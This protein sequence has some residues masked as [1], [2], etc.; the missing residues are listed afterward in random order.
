MKHLTRKVVSLFTALTVAAGLCTLP[1]AAAETPKTEQSSVKAVWPG[2]KLKALTG[3]FDDGT[4]N[5]D[6]EKWLVDTFKANG[7]KATF[8]LPSGNLPDGSMDKY[9]ALYTGFEVAS[10]TK[11]HSFYGNVSPARYIDETRYDIEKLSKIAPDNMV[12]GMAYPNGGSPEEEQKAL[13]KEAGIQYGRSTCSTRTFNLPDDL[14]NW[15]PTCFQYNINDLEADAQK[16]IN[17]APDS[18][19]LMY[20][21]GHSYQLN[22]SNKPRTKAVYEA[23]GNRGDI[24]YAT[25][26]EVANYLKAVDALIIGSDESR[27]TTVYNPSALP[28]FVTV[29]GKCF[30]IPSNTSKTISVAE[31]IVF[32]D[33]CEANPNGSDKLFFARENGISYM[34]GDTAITD[35]STGLPDKGYTRY[36][37]QKG[38][39]H[40]LI[41]KVTDEAYDI[42]AFNLLT[43]KR[44]GSDRVT[45]FHIYVSPDNSDGSYQEIPYAKTQVGGQ[46]NWWLFRYDLTN[47]AALPAGTKY[48]KISFP[49]DFEAKDPGE[50]YTDDTN[51]VVLGHVNLTFSTP[52]SITISDTSPAAPAFAASSIK[53]GASDTAL[54]TDS[55]TLVFN[56]VMNAQ[57][58]NASTISINNGLGISSI[59]PLDNNKTYRIAFDA[60][61]RGNTAYTLSLSGGI[62]AADGT[63]ITPAAIRFT[64]KDPYSGTL[65]D[66]A[67][68]YRYVYMSTGSHNVALGVD[69]DDQVNFARTAADTETSTSSIIYRAPFGDITSVDVDVYRH[70]NENRNPFTI[71]V[72]KDNVTYTKLMDETDGVTAS[73]PEE[74]WCFHN[75]MQRE[76]SEADIKYLK[77]EFPKKSANDGA[78]HHLAQIGKVR[79]DYS[80]P[81]E[82]RSGAKLQNLNVHA[83]DAEQN[84]MNKVPINSFF[85]S[86]GEQSMAEI[87][88]RKVTVGVE[89][90]NFDT[91]QNGRQATVYFALYQGGRLAALY[92]VDVTLP[93]SGSTE[94]VRTEIAL[95]DAGSPAD[96]TL[97]CMLW[98]SLDSVIPLST[99][100]SF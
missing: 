68:D 34:G 24:W 30:E 22:D 20:V 66:T 4:A 63:A 8:A 2:G 74:K 1:Q 25:N 5:Y 98:D 53:D 31:P 33:P 28:V 35:S 70:P 40:S 46:N 36:D 15:N 88:T 71:Y 48:I 100:I 81:H 11:Y 76:I 41:Y 79:F 89:V 72:S 80:L 27:N 19:Q 16:F 73:E 64:T 59:T 94:Y 43:Y 10:H 14:Y 18:M 54:D 7:I 61:L 57:T 44:A 84:L 42:A 50:Q 91:N 78:S 21:W 97:K 85:A 32:N 26:I 6:L 55:I 90:L 49:T 60:A 62:E 99:F 9:K 52:D 51:G 58:V 39:V 69:G 45:E 87:T 77:V 92:P 95:P 56:N 17:L 82:E 29:D 38:R 12:H 65:N 37:M 83:I 96:Y 67:T 3:S 23:L 47:T 86:S 75:K 13:L 93:V